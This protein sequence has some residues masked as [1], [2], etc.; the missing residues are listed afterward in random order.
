MPPPQVIA[1]AQAGLRMRLTQQAGINKKKRPRRSFLLL[2]RCCGHVCLT[3]CY[4]RFLVDESTSERSW[5]WP[6]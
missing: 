3:Q 6:E 5:H 4:F 1:G 2:G